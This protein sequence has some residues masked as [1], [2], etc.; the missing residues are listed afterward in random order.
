MARL[1][2]TS[3]WV[4][5]FRKKSPRAL[6]EIIHPWIIDPAACL[7]EPVAFEVLRHATA[8]ERTLIREQFETLPF[9]PTPAKLWRDA[10]TLGQTCRDSGHTAGSLD[11][12]IATIALHHEAELITLDKDYSAIAKL[13]PLRVQLLTRP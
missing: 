4:D 10:A 7:C 6:K 8:A 13:S 11:L 9:L 3:L 12:I 5:F 2:E 1:I